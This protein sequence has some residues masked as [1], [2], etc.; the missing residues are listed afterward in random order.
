MTFTLIAIISVFAL[1]AAKE[2]PMKTIYDFTVKNIDGKEVSLADFK[3]KTVLIVNVASKCGF[4]PQYEGLEKIYKKYQAKGFTVIGFPANNFMWQEPAD[5]GEIKKF[6]TLNYGVTFPMMSKISVKG[7]DIH[8]LYAFLT[9]KADNPKFS[10]DIGWNF[11]KFLIAKDGTIA[12]RF[13]SK[14]TP[15]SAELIGKVE[16]QLGR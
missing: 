16:E 15:E 9:S 8:P 12:A 7:A 6:C 10:G 4:T 13:E 14:I 11:T 3:G 1:A 5:E 2:K